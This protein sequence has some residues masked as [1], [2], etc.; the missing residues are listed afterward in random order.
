MYKKNQTGWL[1]HLDFILIDLFCLHLSFILAFMIRHGMVWPYSLPAYRNLGLVMTFIDLAVIFLFNSYSKILKRNKYQEFYETCKH[2]LIVT[3]VLMSYTFMSQTGEVYSRITISLTSVIY[4][5]TD[6]VARIFY[7]RYLRTR[8]NRNT[9]SMVVVAKEEDMENTIKNLWSDPFSGF[10]ITGLVVSDKDMAGDEILGIPVISNFDDSSDYIMRN[11]VDEVFIN[12]PYRKYYTQK[13]INQL[14]MMGVTVHTQLTENSGD[15]PATTFVENIGNC[16]VLTNALNSANPT[17]L[18]VKRAVD[19]VGGLVGT[20]ITGMLYLV[21]APMIK[22]QD[23]GPVFFEQ[24]RVGKNGKPFKIYK[25]RSMYQD[26]EEKKKELLEQN[27]VKDGMMFKLTYDPRIIGCKK[28]PDGTIKKGLGNFI[29][30]WSLDEFPQFLN[31]LKGDMSLVGTRPPTPDEW[32]KYKRHHRARMSSK[33]GITGM[34]QIS[35]RSDI[36]D[37]EEVVDLDTYY[38]KNWSLGL[39]FTILFKTIRVVAMRVG[40]R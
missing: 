34:W 1:K 6:W 24:T 28:N 3:M 36:K 27:E 22:S 17:S 38:I 29:R 2:V 26:A 18:M 9:R 14:E 30:D 31:V 10:S 32:E 5:F 39:D 23:P 20:M 8:H 11:W 40:S 15:S 19:I 21:L 35:G 16:T 25:F 12:L 4:L 13:L 37:F 33:P 7:R